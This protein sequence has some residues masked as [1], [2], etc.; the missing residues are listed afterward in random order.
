MAGFGAGASPA[1]STEPAG[2]LRQ[3]RHYGGHT[4]S[5]GYEGGFTFDEGPHVSFTKDERVRSSCSPTT[6]TSKYETLHT[7]VNNYWQGHWIKHPAQGNLHGLPH[8]PGRRRSSRDFVD[9]QQQ[10]AGRDPQLR[11]LAARQLRRHVRRDVPDGVHDQVPHDEARNMSTDWIGPRLYRPKLEE[12]LRGALAPPDPRRPLHQPLPLPLARR[13]RLLPAPVHG[14][15][16]R[17][18]GSR[19]EVASTPRARRSALRERR[20]RAV[21][22]ARL[23]DAAA[24]ADPDRSTGAPADVLEAAARLACS[25]VVIVNLGDRSA[26]T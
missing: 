17:A 1:R 26:P 23:V 20:G 12:V 25:E 6:S 3:A 16:G 7:R 11:G 8:R 19:A 21:R 4:A 24:G 10:R 5:Y 9:A 15:D 14:D 22:R 18:A 13:L 2:P